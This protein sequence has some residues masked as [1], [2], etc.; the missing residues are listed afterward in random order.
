VIV[1]KF[2]EDGLLL[3]IAFAETASSEEFAGF[4]G[5]LALV[6]GEIADDSGNRKPPHKVMEHTVLLSQGGKLVLAAGSLDKLAYLNDF[7]ANYQEALSAE[8]Q[9]ILYVVD[10]T[11]PLQLELKG[12]HF[13]LIPMQEG[14]TWNELLDEAGLDKGD[15]KKMSG[16]DKVYAVWEELKGFKPKGGV[17]SMEEALGKTDA[18]LTRIERGAL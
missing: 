9:A 12:V 7:V 11:E 2:E 10:L 3:N 13:A 16:A 14:I 18:T 4:R 5:R 1:K 17:V 15:L 8:T 6:E